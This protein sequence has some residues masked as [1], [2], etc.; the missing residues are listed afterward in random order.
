MIGSTSSDGSSN[1]F[2]FIAAATLMSEPK[3]EL[4]ALLF[5]SLSSTTCSFS[6]FSDLDA[7]S[8]SAT[9]ELL[10]LL[11][12]STLV[13]CSWELTFSTLTCFPL[14]LESESTLSTSAS[15]ERTKGSLWDQKL[16]Y[17]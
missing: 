12:F 6:N 11:L 14:L 8:P 15:F 4:A 17:C 3:S 7:G 16:N 1:C 9:S 5:S 10:V 13:G 2:G